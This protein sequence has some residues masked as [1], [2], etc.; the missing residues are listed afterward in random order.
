[1]KKI[2]NMK[3]EDRQSLGASARQSVLGRFSLEAMVS[4]HRR[5]YEQAISRFES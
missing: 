2:L 3:A 5:L 1:M 4:A